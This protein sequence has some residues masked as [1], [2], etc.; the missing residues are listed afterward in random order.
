MDEHPVSVVINLL[1]CNVHV[2]GDGMVGCSLTW[3]HIDNRKRKTPNDLICK[4]ECV[5]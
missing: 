5:L 4:V 1:S 2:S 3:V